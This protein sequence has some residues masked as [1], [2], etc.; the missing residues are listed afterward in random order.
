MSE[1]HVKTNSAYVLFYQRKDTIQQNNTQTT[2]Q[3][4]GAVNGAVNGET[5]TERN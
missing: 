1:S 2:T 3:A 4:N 5:Q